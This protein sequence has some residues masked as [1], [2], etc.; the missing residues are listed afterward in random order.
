MTH[1]KIKEF[2]VINVN[3]K[4]YLKTTINVFI[5]SFIYILKKKQ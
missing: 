3:V 4:K 1:I 5:Y 2:M